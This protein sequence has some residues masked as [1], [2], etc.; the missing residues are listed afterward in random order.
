[1]VARA[2]A[3]LKIVSQHAVSR[4]LLV[5]A[6]QTC[7]RISANVR[8]LSPHAAIAAV[9]LS[10]AVLQLPVVTLVVMAA[11]TAATPT[12]AAVLQQAAETEMVAEMAATL[13]Q[14]AALQQA[15]VTAATPTQ[16]AVHQQVAEMA[17]TLTPAAVLQQA[18]ATD[19]ATDVELQAVVKAAIAATMIAAKLLS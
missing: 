1:M 2:A 11:E 9:L 12:Q 15:V 10:H 4:Q 19:A 5:R 3:V 8:T 7:T 13:T 6:A 14:A 16:F 18:A 17:A